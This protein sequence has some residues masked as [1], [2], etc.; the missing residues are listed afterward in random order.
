MSFFDKITVANFNLDT[1][2]ELL[3]WRIV[4]KRYMQYSSPGKCWF[5]EYLT[6]V[7]YTLQNY[8][9]EKIDYWKMKAFVIIFVR[10][11]CYKYIM[12]LQL[13][14]SLIMLLEVIPNW[15]A[16]LPYLLPSMDGEW[17]DLDDDF[18][19]LVDELAD[20]WC[21]WWWWWNFLLLV[22]PLE[23]VG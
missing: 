23:E 14:L 16:L 18:S 6:V 22:K 7:F 8:S 3:S 10:S 5:N 15:T 21:C 20:G 13:I 9:L 1:D 19:D 4:C 2:D 11:W 12:F 17:E